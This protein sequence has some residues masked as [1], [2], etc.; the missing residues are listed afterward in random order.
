MQAQTQPIIM[1]ESLSIDDLQDV[2]DA[3][4]DVKH[5]WLK[6]GLALRLRQ[7]VLDGFATKHH[8]DPDDCYHEVL[9]EWLNNVPNPS[10]EKLVK[11]LQ[12]DC[13]R[14]SNIADKIAKDHCP[15]MQKPVAVAVCPMLGKTKK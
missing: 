11:A 8:N 14:H 1:A 3:T 7:P 4:I 9:K 6:M 5:L 13:V 10:W 12:S 15:H 2:L